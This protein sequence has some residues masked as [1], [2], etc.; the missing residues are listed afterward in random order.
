MKTKPPIPQT[1][2]KKIALW[3]TKRRIHKHKKRYATLWEA[4]VD[5]I[6]TPMFKRVAKQTK[7]QMIKKHSQAYF[8]KFMASKEKKIKFVLDIFRSIKKDGLTTWPKALHQTKETGFTPPKWIVNMT[9]EV[10]DG[11]AVPNKY[12]LAEARR[13]RLLRGQ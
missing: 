10:V 3:L 12:R 13:K 7:S 5:F 11:K 6:K 8:D 1:D 9:K 4:A 2:R